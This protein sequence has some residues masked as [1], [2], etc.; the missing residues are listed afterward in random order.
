[1]NFDEAIDWLFGTQLFGIKLGLEN[2]TRL[3]RETGVF[4]DL[5]GRKI[6]HVAGTNGK[7]SV[8][9]MADSILR[10]SGVKTGLFTSPHL[11][12]FGERI[13]VDG[14]PI[15]EAD[16]ATLLTEL[17]DQIQDWDPHPTF[18]EITLALALRHFCDSDVEA[19]ILETGMGGR[20]DAT[21]ALSADVSVITQIGLDHQQWLGETIREIAAEKAGILKPET[22]VVVADVLPEAR[23]VIGRRALELG[24]PFIEAHPLP[25]EWPIGV[26][27]A[28][29]RENA[30]LAVEAVCRIFDDPR[31]S[32]RITR[33]AIRDGLANVSWPGRFQKVEADLIVDGA[34]NPDAV[35]A[36][37]ETW[38]DQF[39]DEKACVLFGSVESKDVESVL[40]LLAPITA[41]TIL[42]P[43]S[44]QRGLPTS[45]LRKFAPDAIEADSVAAGFDMLQQEN[46][47]KLVTGSLFLAGEVLGIVGGEL[48]Q[49]SEQ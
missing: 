45:N 25:A 7:G 26:P 41:K 43:V 1:M 20:L 4:D 35:R 2:M 32:P 46:G 11:I 12:S 15:P 28:H 40:N 17:R 23:D 22:P 16:T 19:I 3:L 18:F 5:S 33:E 38:R 24:I 48:F 34:H 49:V 31:K 14:A 30:A 47:L 42:V 8:C 39:G 9:A 29:M 6:I 36:L 37:V 27:G 10:E 13:R 44:S 21:N